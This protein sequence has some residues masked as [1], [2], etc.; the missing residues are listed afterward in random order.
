MIALLEGRLT[1]AEEL[2]DAAHSL[3]ERAQGWS[4]AVTYRLQLYVLRREQGRLE[5]IEPLIRRSVDEYP[6]YPIWHC[7]L[8]HMLARAGPRGRGARGVRGSRG[9]RLRRAAVRRG[10]AR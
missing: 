3:G 4:A 10:V 8:V 6:T 1:E 9:G 5:E 2:I 7:V